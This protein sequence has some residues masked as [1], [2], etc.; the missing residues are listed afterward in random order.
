MA[1]GTP[2]SVDDCATPV[3]GR[4]YCMKH[5]TRV[6]R[7]GDPDFV[8][9]ERFL[10]PP[11]GLCTV[12]GCEHPNKSRGWCHK[13]YTRWRR[14]GSVAYKRIVN[15][16]AEY[17]CGRPCQARGLCSKHYQRLWEKENPDLVRTYRKKGQ[18][19]RREYL[20]RWQSENADRVREYGRKWQQANRLAVAEKSARRRAMRRN[21]TIMKFT[22][23][24]LEDRLSMFSGCWLCGGIAD[25]IDHVKPLIAG[26]P[27]CL[28][29]LRP[30]C[31]SCNSAK[32]GKWGE[33][34][35]RAGR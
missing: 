12:D 10:A 30:A 7:Y 6:R 3:Y 28:A 31:R 17:G 2:C 33:S 11:D 24:E 9:Y 27:H 19:A 13:H 18:T 4:G 14:T 1:A 26:G 20:R 34:Q 23:D 15:Y 29:N 8:T 35:C 16:C 5:Y 32:G 22:R 25:T 21:A